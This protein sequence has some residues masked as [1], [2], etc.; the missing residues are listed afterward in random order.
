MRRPG[1]RSQ[2]L[3]SPH[4]Q[5]WD[6]C[7]PVEIQNTHDPTT[8]TT[9]TSGLQSGLTRTLLRA[10]TALALTVAG[11]A[12][13]AP[14]GQFSVS[15]AGK[16]I[17][18]GGSFA[19]N[20]G[21]KQIF[22]SKLY[23]YEFKAK[24]KGEP[25]TP[26]GALVPSGTSLANFVDSLKPG[27]SKKLG[28]T[29]SNP[30]GTLPTKVIDLKVSGTRP[31]KGVPGLTQIKIAM[32][33]V[34]SIDANGKVSLDVKNVQFVGTPKQKMGSVTFQTG[35]KLLVSAAPEV[36]F[37]RGNIT[38]DED[39]GIAQIPVRRGVNSKGKVTVK[40]ATADGT[41]NSTHYTPTSGT[42]TFNDGELQKF[43][44]V[45]LLDNNLNDGARSFTINLSEPGGGAVL[46]STGTSINVNIHDDE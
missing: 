3:K 10:A 40:Y 21:T 9:I 33:I 35:S 31:V 17:G 18:N 5:A 41:A 39:S 29:F 27:T 14:L 28:G 32:N 11:T 43:I 37:L 22:P 7:Q 38:F 25:G 19:V 44:P 15:I 34:G 42:V 12:H 24:M 16:T 6:G 45:T 13:A 2:P 30:S 26:L 4:P 8:M 23:K 36:F 1:W 20:S 46:A